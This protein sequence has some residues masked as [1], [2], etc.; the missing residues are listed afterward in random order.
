[1]R[2]RNSR[3][4]FGLESNLSRGMALNTA[5]SKGFHAAPGTHLSHAYNFKRVRRILHRSQQCSHQ[6]LQSHQ[7]SF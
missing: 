1:M 6:L 2:F 3:D 7:P 4:Y 5:T